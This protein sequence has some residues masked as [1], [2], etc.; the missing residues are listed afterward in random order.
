M[1]L[2]D[3]IPLWL[4][5][6]AT[7]FMLGAPFSPEPHLVE[8]A[9]MFQN[10]T[11]SRPIDLFDVFWHLLPAMLLVIRIVRMRASK[12]R[13]PERAESDRA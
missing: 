2:I 13:P 4:L 7:A 1:H 10:G 8:K 3:K 11:L 5:V 6:L 9:R 12:T